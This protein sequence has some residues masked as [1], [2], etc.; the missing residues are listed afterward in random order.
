MNTHDLRVAVRDHIRDH[1]EQFNMDYWAR[2]STHIWDLWNIP[3]KVTLGCGTVACLAGTAVALYPDMPA[4]THPQGPWGVPGIGIHDVAR[5]LDV[6]VSAFYRID[7]DEVLVDDGTLDDWYHDNYDE[8][9]TVVR[10]LTYL[11]EEES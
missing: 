8:A 11:I 9:A 10:Y 4:T 5:A 1:P 3:G 7:W 6:T 2:D